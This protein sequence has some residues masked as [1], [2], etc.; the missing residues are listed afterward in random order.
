MTSIRGHLLT[1]VALWLA[2]PAASVAQTP[3]PPATQPASAAPANSQ[4]APATYDIDYFDISGVSKLDQLTVEKAVYPFTG[5]R[6]SNE[7]VENARKALEA[8]YRA[9][10]LE[11]VVVDI[12]PQPATLFSRGVVTLRV[13]ESP[14]GRVRVV[15][16]KYH[17]PVMVKQAIPALKEGDVPDLRA[18]QA[19][20]DEA[21]RFP[22]REVTPSLKPGKVPGTIDVDLRM[23]SKLPF[24]ASLEV[25]NDHSSTT[26]PTRINAGLRYTN[27]WQLGHTVSF[28]YLVSPEDRS[29]SEV[30]SGSYLAPVWGTKWT[31]LLFGYTSN[32]NVPSAAGTTVLGNGFQIGAR[33]IY[34]LPPGSNYFHSLTLGFDYKDFTENL[35]LASQPGQPIKTPIAYVPFSAAYTF[36]TVGNRLNTNLTAGLTAG[37]RGIG[38]NAQ[39]V[40]NKRASAIGSFVH[41]N[42][43]GDISY[44]LP[45]G[46]E[47]YTR[48]AGQLSDSPLVTNEQL[49]GGGA[50]SVRGY[51]QSEVVGDEGVVGG[52]ELR[53]PS[54]ARYLG[55]RVD[56]LRLFAFMDGAYLTLRS[57]LAEQDDEFALM[58]AGFGARFQLFKYLSGNLT[59]GFPLRT[60]TASSRGDQQFNFSVK[61]EV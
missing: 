16:A 9:R 23:K 4:P 17:L 10:G 36:G 6:K 14:L 7:D 60:S 32:S 58:S 56:D 35:L 30:F 48:F 27:L 37:V 45:R 61:A 8:A 5:P 13:I 55:S 43:D 26:T 51:F 33:A 41:V 42:L 1:A 29:E 50:L 47:V 38:S 54:L 11:S 39:D 46:F 28:N 18:V 57:P 20:I 22:D 53:S 34:R 21:N 40:T 49:A 52:F 12:P 3:T 59:L 2:A 19:Q 25:N 44:Q 15:G 24:H 31:L